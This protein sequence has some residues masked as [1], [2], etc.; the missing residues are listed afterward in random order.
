MPKALLNPDRCRPE[1]CESGRCA[2]RSVCKV[3]AIYQDEPFEA[4]FVD[5]SRCH[6][7]SKCVVACPAKAI[8]LVD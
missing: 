4:P 3:K 1:E 7:C 2:V 6:A 8:S 5:W